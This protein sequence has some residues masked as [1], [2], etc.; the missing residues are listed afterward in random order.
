MKNKIPASWKNAGLII[1]GSFLYAVGMNVFIAPLDLFSGGG[2]GLSQLLAMFLERKIQIEG[3]NLYGI[4]NMLLNIPLLILAFR[5]IGKSF[6][7]KPCWEPAAS[8]FLS[9]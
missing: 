1:F 4:I 5:G 9:R 7:L 6:L 2:V 8:A 3:I